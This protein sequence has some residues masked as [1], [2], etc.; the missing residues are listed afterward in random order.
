MT[1]SRQG[2]SYA[3]SA[4]IMTAA[5]VV[6]VF[7]TSVYTYQVLEQQRGAAE[8]QVAEKSI[9]AFDDALE[10]IAW[11]P[12]GTRSTQF[13]LD[14]GHLELVD[15]I[16][17]RVHAVGYAGASRNFTTGLLR[18]TTQ[19]TYMN[20]GE[21]YSAYILG[22]NQLISNSTGSYGQAVVEQKAGWVSITLAYGVRAMETSTVTV[23]QGETHVVSYVDIWIIQVQLNRT[24][25]YIGSFELT[26]SCLDVKTSSTAEYS[27]TNR[28]F[29]LSAQLGSG[30]P[31]ETLI[32]LSPSADTVVFNF[33]VATVKV[34][35]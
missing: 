25:T 16:P 2:V 1:R 28:Q 32:R 18:Y 17:L 29:S 11:K 8:F 31:T 9:L 4:V 3:I 5:I 26:A 34:T 12:Q 14:Y 27:I 22:S 13:T 6:L 33:V 35:I 20:F 30:N 19:T 15:N 10:N 24:A 21:N 23:T 7:V